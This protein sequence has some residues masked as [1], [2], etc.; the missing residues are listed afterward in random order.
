ML[1][2]STNSPWPNQPFWD[3]SL[4]I[5]VMSTSKVFGKSKR[6]FV[7]HTW[8]HRVT[9]VSAC[10]IGQFGLILW[11]KTSDGAHF[12]VRAN[13]KIKTVLDQKIP[14]K[15]Y[16]RCKRLLSVLERLKKK[17]FSKTILNKSYN[18]CEI[19]KIPTFIF[20]YSKV[21]PLRVLKQFSLSM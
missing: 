12:L 16:W 5:V 20:C 9:V 15:N 10:P 6:F 7:E 1:T 14:L 18:I 4:Y 21:L 19:Q 17:L 13:K 11:Q 3:S 8:L 2:W